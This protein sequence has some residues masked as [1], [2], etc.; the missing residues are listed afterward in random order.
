[1]A[2]TRTWYSIAR[3]NESGRFEL[4]MNGDVLIEHHEKM[5]SKN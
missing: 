1:M 4:V 5:Q 2:E 3:K